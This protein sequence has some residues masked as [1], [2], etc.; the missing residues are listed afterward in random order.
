MGFIFDCTRSTENR[1]IF[2]DFDSKAILDVTLEGTNITSTH[3]SDKRSD[4]GYDFLD[5]NVSGE[6]INTWDT[7]KWIDW[8]VGYMTG[9]TCDEFAA[10]MS[11]AV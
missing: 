11:K 3:I 5:A 6:E 8:H 10:N 9:I 7:T 4:S 1:L 2:I